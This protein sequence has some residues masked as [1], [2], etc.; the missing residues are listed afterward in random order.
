MT[1]SG[2]G[3]RTSTSN[4]RVRLFASSL[5]MPSRFTSDSLN[6]DPTRRTGFNAVIGSWKII[7]ILVPQ[8]PRISSLLK[9]RSSCPS[10]FTLPVRFTLRPRSKPIDARDITVLPEPDSP[11]IPILSPLLITS[12]TPRTAFKGPRAVSNVISKFSISNRGLIC[13]TLCRQSSLGSNRRSNSR[14][15]R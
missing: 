12:D 3:I 1:F 5:D 7:A 6:W 13:V 11:T 9:V 15:S 14:P 10:S 4:S 2:S 8:S